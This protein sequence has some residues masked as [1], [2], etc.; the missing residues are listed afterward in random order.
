[1]SQVAHHIPW[2]IELQMPPQWADTS[3]RFHDVA[4]DRRQGSRARLNRSSLTALAAAM[5]AIEFSFAISARSVQTRACSPGAI[6][7]YIME[8]AGRVGPLGGICNSM[9]QGMWCATDSF[10][11]NAAYRF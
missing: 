11:Q 4:L 1:M 5:K 7:R 8:T 3:G 9:P 6:Q 2:G 10:F